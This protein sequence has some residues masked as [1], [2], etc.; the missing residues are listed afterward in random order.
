MAYGTI[1]AIELHKFQIKCYKE[2][3]H[4]FTY[5]EIMFTISLQVILYTILQG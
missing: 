1:I 5:Q 4:S 2:S 3:R